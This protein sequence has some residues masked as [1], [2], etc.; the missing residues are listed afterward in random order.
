MKQV[1]DQKVLQLLGDPFLAAKGSSV[2]S[3]FDE[4]AK[5]GCL[6]G[7]AFHYH[8]RTLPQPLPKSSSVLLNFWDCH[9][10]D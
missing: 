1:G 2:S 4:G 8:Q 7:R 6:V 9:S 3:V 10:L 5:P